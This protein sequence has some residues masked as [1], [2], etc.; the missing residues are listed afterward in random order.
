MRRSLL[1]SFVSAVIYST[2]CL[3]ISAQSSAILKARDA[4]QA[5]RQAAQK[6]STADNAA[7]RVTALTDTIGIYESGLTA[8]REGLR[9]V[10]IQERAMRNEFDSRRDQISRLLG[11]LQTLERATTPLLLIHPTGP[12]GTARSGMMLSEITPALQTQAE[13]L[14]A[15]LEELQSIELLQKIAEDDLLIGLDGLSKARVALSQ[16]IANRVD[17]PKRFATDP[18]KLQILAETS[19]TLD[20]FADSLEELQTNTIIEDAGIRTAN[21][22]NALGN[23]TLPVHSN[24]LRKFN[25]KDAT[26]LARPGIV[27]AT[28]PL[29]LVTAPWPATV[30]FSGSFLDYGNV[31]ILEPDPDYLIIITGLGQNYVSVGDIVNKDDPLG[32]IGGNALELDDLMLEVSQNGTT[33][34]QET[35]YLEIRKNKV[36]VDPIDWFKLNK[37]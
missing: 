25:E 27:L 34:A 11:I 5:L 17:L 23:L 18:V 10:V 3:S 15:N 28:E 24:I 30:R 35:L 22:E 32:I 12:V 21:F 7:D 4:S 6:L 19:A 2:S 16:A 36:P 29:S 31:I 8:M 26:G 20:L 37:G 13:E 9:A 1:I 14:R 33:L